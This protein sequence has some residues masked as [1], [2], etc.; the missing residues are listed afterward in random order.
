MANRHMKR[1]STSLVIRVMQI[2][3]SM[4]YHF[5]PVRMATIQKTKTNVGKVVEKWEPTYTAGGNVN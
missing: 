4:R 2:K 1:Y 3:T 5:I